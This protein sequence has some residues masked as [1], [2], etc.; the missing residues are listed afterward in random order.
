MR[1][2]IRSFRG[3]TS[4]VYRWIFAGIFPLALIVLT[5]VVTEPKYQMWFWTV[6]FCY[7]AY[8]SMSD[9]LAFSGICKKENRN[10]TFLKLSYRGD[11][12]FRHV[13]LVDLIR[14]FLVAA[15]MGVIGW[16]QNPDGL[17][18]TVILV[19]YVVTI[20]II[21]VVRY[22]DEIRIYLSIWTM[23]F[24]PLSL[25]VV[26][27]AKK[28]ASWKMTPIVAMIGIIIVVGLNVLT[29]QHMLLRERGVLHEEK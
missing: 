4:A 3:Y 25:L 10:C 11:R 12:M 9:Y 18:W 21:N 29:M 7:I 2:M 5:Y 6:I 14:R 17:V 23:I 24:A 1:D 19:L 8:E 20:L 13:V 16:H 27:F 28:I 22:I 15:I 26:T